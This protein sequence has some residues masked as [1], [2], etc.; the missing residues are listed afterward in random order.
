M[1]FAFSTAFKKKGKKKRRHYKIAGY[2]FVCLKK[3]FIRNSTRDFLIQVRNLL[4]VKIYPKSADSALSKDIKFL[5]QALKHKKKIK[6]E[7]KIHQ[8]LA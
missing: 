2:C 3:Q 4:P 8:K 6:P 1:L 7:I 5:R